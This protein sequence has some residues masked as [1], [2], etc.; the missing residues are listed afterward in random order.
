[1]DR[2]NE[3]GPYQPVLQQGSDR[4]ATPLATV[5]RRRIH[6]SS[7]ITPAAQAW[8]VGSATSRNESNDAVRQMEAS[9]NDDDDDA[10]QSYWL[11]SKGS[12]LLG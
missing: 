2:C 12:W 10:I 4:Y 7:N 5:A 8:R 9:D 1:M 3:N 6:A 11:Y